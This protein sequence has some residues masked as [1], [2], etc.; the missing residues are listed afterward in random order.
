[1]RVAEHELGNAN[2]SWTHESNLCTFPEAFTDLGS[3]FHTLTVFSHEGVHLR[4]PRRGTRTAPRACRH[5]ITYADS[6]TPF[7]VGARLLKAARVGTFAPNRAAF[8]PKKNAYVESV[9]ADSPTQPW[10]GLRRGSASGRHLGPETTDLSQHRDVQFL[11]RG[12]CEFVQPSNDIGQL[13]GHRL[14]GADLLL[15]PRNEISHPGR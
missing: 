2:L 3:K 6:L 8:Y 14:A 11:V 1:M 4:T 12:V 13:S 9:A 15:H 5:G 10:A 7:P